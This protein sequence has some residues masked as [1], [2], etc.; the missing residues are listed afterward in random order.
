MTNDQSTGVARLTP[1]VIEGEELVRF[2]P[3][4]KEN[5]EVHGSKPCVIDEIG[6]MSWAEF[7]DLV[8]RIAGRLRSMGIGPGS[9][10]ASLAENSANNVA[11]YAGVLYAGACMVPLPFSATEAALVKE[12]ADCGATLLFTTHQFRATAEKLGASEIVDLAEIEAWVGDAPAIDPVPV[13]DDDLFDM[14]YSS[15]T[16]GTPKGIVHDHRFRSRQFSRTSAYGLEADGVL[17]LST[18][19]Y[20]NTTLVAAIAGLVRGATLVTMARFDTVRFLELSERHRATHAML[21][22]VQY[23][24]LM[25]EPRFD[26]FDLSS[27][28]CKMST[29]APLP[30]VLIAQCMERWP[31]NILEFYGMT[32]GGPATV[33]DCA[34]H[35]DKWDTVGQP[36]P[37]AD[38]RVIDEEGNELPYGA[39]GEVVGRSGSMMPGYHNNPEKTREA[40]WVSPEGDHFVRTGDMG[41]FDED[42]FLHLLDRKKDMI[43]SG[44]FN[45]Y[46]ADLEAVLRKHPDVADVAVI[47]I[48]SREWGETPLGLVVPRRPEADAEAIRDWTND[49]LGKTQRL[50]R[51]EFRQDLPRSEIGKILKRE[52]RAPYWEGQPA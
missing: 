1:K 16:T 34:A 3:R 5:A 12:R 48:P 51:I 9:M 29:S 14:I 11:M 31:G 26:E 47:A 6:T 49:Q 21:V 18:P 23:M 35:P 28:Q 25:D 33:L 50:S 4:M 40:T 2:G 43:I 19:L 17:M 41:R 39:Y 8:A 22:P 37:G 10:V 45:I 30:G 42:G 24:R 46:A 20:S 52:L 15:G 7:G 38:M 44:G 32:E 27:Y 36:Q 13:T